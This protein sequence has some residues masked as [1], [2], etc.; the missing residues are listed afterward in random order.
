MATMMEGR[1]GRNPLNVMYPKTV[2]YSEKSDWSG[3]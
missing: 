1:E 2:S 3:N